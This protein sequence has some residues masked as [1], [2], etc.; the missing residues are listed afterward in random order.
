MRKVIE[1]AALKHGGQKRKYNN[2]PYI[3]HP[4]R[5]AGYV[6]LYFPSLDDSATQAA[7][8][9]DTIEDTDATYEEILSL[10]GKTTADLVLELT[11]PSSFKNNRNLRRIDRNVLDIKHLESCSYDAQSVKIC[12][13]YD[14]VRDFTYEQAGG[15]YFKYLREQ[16]AKLSVIDHKGPFFNYVYDLVK[17]KLKDE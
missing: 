15:F 2:E 8:L 9:H 6:Q 5:V 3:H 13:I 14:N 7:W 16:E 11:N 17:E 4:M 12:D 1:F 10:F